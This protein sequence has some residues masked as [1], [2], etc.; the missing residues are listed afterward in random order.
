MLI[1][2]LD[3]IAGIFRF[4]LFFLS[5]FFSHSVVSRLDISISHHV[6]QFDDVSS[7]LPLDLLEF[8]NGYTLSFYFLR[9]CS[10]RDDQRSTIQ[11]YYES[12]VGLSS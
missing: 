12:T 5:F 9:L 6:F 1:T 3:I 11:C 10:D 7:S 2:Q 4:D 8:G